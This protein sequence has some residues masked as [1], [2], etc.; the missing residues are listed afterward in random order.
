MPLELPSDDDALE[1]SSEARPRYTPE[2]LAAIFLDF[3][4]FLTT[5][6]YKPE[7]LKVPPPEGWGDKVHR[8]CK[9]D[10]AVEVLRRLPYFDSED[11]TA[12]H[13]K[14][15]LLDYTSLPPD[16]F[17]ESWKDT[18]G[19]YYDFMREDHPVDPTDVVFIA[20][21][22]ESG[23][24]EFLLDVHRGE[25]TMDVIRCNN[26]DAVDVKEFF[27]ALKEEYRSL[28]LIPYKGSVPMEAEDISECDE[29]ITEAEI[30]AQPEDWWT[31]LD[32][33]YVRQMYRS[34][35]WPDAFRREEAWKAMDELYEAVQEAGR[36]YWW[37]CQ[38]R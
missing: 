26:L 37:E 12:I 25:M 34:Y 38:Q 19:D 21:G 16:Y 17:A 13:Y 27:A 11:V 14:S 3:Y 22:Y 9:S 6:H 35:G 32:A 29:E 15:S 2:E 20:T 23:G 8:H 10:Y 4:Q 36:D 30:C 24:R 18:A 7:S 28:R 31:E 33:L 1:N 5:L